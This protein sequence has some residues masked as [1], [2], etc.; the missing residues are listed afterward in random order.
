LFRNYRKND[1]SIPDIVEI[2]LVCLENAEM[3]LTIIEIVENEFICFIN[4]INYRN[5]FNLF[6]KVENDFIC[7]RNCRK[8]LIFV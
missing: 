8:I 5:Y 7:C 1:V 6:R 4:C 3:S 2:T